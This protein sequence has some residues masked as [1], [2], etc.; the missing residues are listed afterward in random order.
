MAR[1][2]VA[3]GEIPPAAVEAEVVAMATGAMAK[4]TVAPDLPSM[5]RTASVACST[6]RPSLSR[7]LSC[8][9]H[10]PSWVGPVE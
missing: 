3:T 6:S 7:A 8:A 1:S 5:G 10:S 4:V 9:L 2:A